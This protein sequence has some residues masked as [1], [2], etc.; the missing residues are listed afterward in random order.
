MSTRLKNART[1]II[2]QFEAA[3]KRVY[4]TTELRDLMT[5]NWVEWDLP[6]WLAMG[7]VREFLLSKTPLRKVTLRCQSY[8][9]VTR[10]V[11][12]KASV[13]EVAASL[14][15]AAYLSHGTA[16]ALHGLTDR[17]QKTV[18][19]NHEQSPKPPPSGG[20]TQDRI[21]R[22]FGRPQRMSKYEFRLA[23]H[24]IRLLNGKNTKRLGV[25]TLKGPEGED[26]SVTNV[27]R[28]LIDIVVRPAYAGGIR[29][30]LEAFETARE[31]VSGES[32]LTTLE[33]MGY[34]YP[35]H[36]PI[37]FLMERAGYDEQLCAQ[38]R[39]R[40]AEFDFYLVHGMKKRRYDKI[41]RLYYP[42]RF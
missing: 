38:L 42:E 4:L 1:H 19:V 22:A 33:G 40:G 41:W 39:D 15:R 27:E 30:V 20:L 16:M 36:Q 32:L 21:D 6:K 10:Y 11:W 34:I 26:L 5:A 18:Y 25:E 28:T 37:G 31:R 35:Y 9:A 14:R 12:G 24:R 3:D 13:Y 8:R 23:R 17:I 7:Q 2:D 29:Q